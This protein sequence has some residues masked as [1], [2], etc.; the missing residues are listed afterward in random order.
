MLL[1]R[2]FNIY[3]GDQVLLILVEDSAF[4]PV[5]STLNRKNTGQRSNSNLYWV[6]GVQAGRKNRPGME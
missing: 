2:F 6:V 1:W 5:G 4:S 3:V